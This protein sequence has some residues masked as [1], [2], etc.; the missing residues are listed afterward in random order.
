MSFSWHRNPF[1]ISFKVIILCSGRF[2]RFFRRTCWLELITKLIG[3]Y[4]RNKST[5]AA[6]D[7]TW[8][9]NR[10]QP[11]M[12]NLNRLEV[13]IICLLWSQA[14]DVTLPPIS[15][16]NEW[17]M[18]I[19]AAHIGVRLSV[20]ERVVIVVL[21]DSNWC[22]HR[23]WRLDSLINNQMSQMEDLTPPSKVTSFFFFPNRPDLRLET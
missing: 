19:T 13:S 21:I 2:S 20:L 17:N 5:S 1:V 9:I 12:I 15:C 11:G 6:L 4:V 3:L 23:V 7:C 16:D 8:T 18:S 10:L 14:S 22:L